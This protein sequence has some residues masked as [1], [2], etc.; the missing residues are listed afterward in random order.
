MVSAQVRAA[1]LRALLSAVA[2]AI[3]AYGGVNLATGDAAE[4]AARSAVENDE[5]DLAG[6]AAEDVADDAKADGEEEAGSQELAVAGITGLVVL[7]VRGGGEGFFDDWRQRNRKSKASDV[8]ATEP[9]P[10]AQPI[11]AVEPVVRAELNPAQARQLPGPWLQVTGR[12]DWYYIL[13][14]RQTDRGTTEY[15]LL[16]PGEH[17]E[18][19]REDKI[20]KD[21]IEL[22]G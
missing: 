10:E 20:R 18:W 15:F 11:A 1:L 7:L 8:T 14:V 5:A 16:S 17:P 6:S 2:A 21:T 9:A 19:V 22:Y 12:D 3:V 13:G 4:S